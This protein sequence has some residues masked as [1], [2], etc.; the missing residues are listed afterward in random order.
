M[1]ETL[2]KKSRVTWSLI[3]SLQTGLLL[4]TGLAGFMSARCPVFN[5]PTILGLTASLFLAISGS[6]VLNMWY[7]RD[8]DAR[9]AR[10]CHRPLPA[11]LVEPKE[12]LLLGLL[13]AASGTGWALLIDPLY[14][15]VVIA[16][17]FFDVGV[18]TV[19]LKR[20]NGLVDHLGRD[21]RGDARVGWTYIGVG[22]DRLDRAGA[23]PGGVVLDPH[24][25]HDF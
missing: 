11:G 15:L 20:R 1:I 16:G 23:L 8:I 13:L 18:Y 25:Y 24:P 3:K 2:T 9:M 7:D 4:T 5:L 17:L 6:T 21:R 14:G 12:A 19:W 22:R 10:T